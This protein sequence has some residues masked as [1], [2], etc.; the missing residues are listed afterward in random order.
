MSEPEDFSGEKPSEKRDSEDW[1][2]SEGKIVRAMGTLKRANP[3]LYRLVEEY[4]V[5]KGKKPWEVISEAVEYYFKQADALQKMTGDQLWAA[6]EFFK[7][8]HKEFIGTYITNYI[9]LV[10]KTVEHAANLYGVME[11]AASRATSQQPSAEDPAAEIKRKVMGQ[12]MQMV[13]PMVTS[14]LQSALMP[15]MPKGVQSIMSSHT[16]EKIKIIDARQKQPTSESPPDNPGSSQE[17]QK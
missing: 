9:E 4:A 16:Q 5:E 12:V 1:A 3:Q 10:T 15:M 8:M 6:W 14:M 11:N 17:P 13:M 7:D 2:Q